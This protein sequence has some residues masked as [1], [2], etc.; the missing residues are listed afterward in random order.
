MTCLRHWFYDVAL[1]T[2]WFCS[3]FPVSIQ[4][5]RILAI[6]GFINQEQLPVLSRLICKGCGLITFFVAGIERRR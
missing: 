1:I 6:A 2:S 3:R 5:K 4:R